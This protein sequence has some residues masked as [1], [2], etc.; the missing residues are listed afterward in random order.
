MTILRDRRVKIES[1]TF[2]PQFA[3]M[4]VTLCPKFD[5]G[6]KRLKADLEAI[7]DS[8]MIVISPQRATRSLSE[9]YAD[10]GHA[11]FHERGPTMSFGPLSQRHF[12]RAVWD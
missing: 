3:E 2:E 6:P 8:P 10:L 5:A 12:Q 1:M 11:A 9:P 7:S 4:A